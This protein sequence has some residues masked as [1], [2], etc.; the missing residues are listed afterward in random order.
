[1][2]QNSKKIDRPAVL[3]AVFYALGPSHARLR[4]PDRGRNVAAGRLRVKRLNDLGIGFHITGVQFGPEMP[5]QG[6]VVDRPAGA[7]VDDKPTDFLVRNTIAGQSLDI[8]ALLF[9]RDEWVISGSWRPCIG[10]FSRHG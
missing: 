9:R 7:R 5:P 8:V 1:M 4:P 2:Q 10:C 6:L 3:A